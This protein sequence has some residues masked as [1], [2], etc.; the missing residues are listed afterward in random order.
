MMYYFYNFESES[1]FWTQCMNCNQP[2]NKQGLS[3]ELPA[4]QLQINAFVHLWSN[5]PADGTED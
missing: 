2:Y 5:E 4:P 3:A 1:F